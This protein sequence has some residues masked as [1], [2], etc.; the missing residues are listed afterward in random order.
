MYNLQEK[1]SSYSVLN[2]GWVIYEKA[3]Y[4]GRQMYHHDGDCFS[5]DPPNPKGLKLKSWQTTIGS[6]RPVTGT[7]LMLVSLRVEPDWS[8]METSVTSEVLGTKEAK[9]TTFRQFP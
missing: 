8:K 7:D 6:I 9:N 3:N 1:P 4:K 5:N 2:G